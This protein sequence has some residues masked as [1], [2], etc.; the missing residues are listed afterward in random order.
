MLELYF[1]D[2]EVDRAHEDA[3]FESINRSSSSPTPENALEDTV[4]ITIPDV[5]MRPWTP[6]V[7]NWSEL[8]GERTIHAS[9]SLIYHRDW[10]A[11]SLRRCHPSLWKALQPRKQRHPGSFG[12]CVV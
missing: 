5:E 6:E 8:R 11:Q 2:E 9:R 4:S 12:P 3:L 10:N 7:D 1:I